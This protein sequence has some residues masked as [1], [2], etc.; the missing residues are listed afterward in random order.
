MTKKA[1]V[2]PVL[3]EENSLANAT[4]VSGAISGPCGGFCG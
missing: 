4:L 3:T 1:F 2:A